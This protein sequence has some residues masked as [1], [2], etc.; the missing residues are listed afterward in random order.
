VPEAMGERVAANNGGEGGSALV[1]ADDPVTSESRKPP[2]FLSG[3]GGLVST[4][5]DYRRFCQ[6][7]LNGGRY[8]GARLISRKT[9]E[10]MTQNHLPE[11]RDLASL[12]TGTFSEST[13]DGVG[14]GLGFA[15]VVDLAKRGLHGS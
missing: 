1:A 13:Y 7:L 5:E 10:L 8:N 4:A 9:I 3:G 11:G 2:T 15:V 14:F 6:M 12:A